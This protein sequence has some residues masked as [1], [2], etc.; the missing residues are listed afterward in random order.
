MGSQLG[1]WM[2]ISAIT[3]IEF[4][5]L[6]CL[7]CCFLCTDLGLG[8]TFLLL[9]SGLSDLSSLLAVSELP[10]L[11]PLELCM[12]PLLS[13]FPPEL[14]LGRLSVWPT[15]FLMEPLSEAGPLIVPLLRLTLSKQRL[16]EA[17]I[18]ARMLCLLPRRTAKKEMF[19]IQSKSDC[20]TFRTN[21]GK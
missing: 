3:M 1:L 4:V 15:P 8:T 13:P 7:L 6:S 19:N 10:E 14:C 5:A 21:I 20:L 9:L 11:T 2:G 16:E 18:D 17:R 12:P